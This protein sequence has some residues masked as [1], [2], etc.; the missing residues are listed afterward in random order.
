MATNIISI[1]GPLFMDWLADKGGRGAIDLVM[2]VQ[3]VE[4]K[5]AVEWLSGRDLSQRPADFHT[6][7]HAEEREPRSLEMPA[8]NE[9]RWDAVREYLGG[10]SQ[11]PGSISGSAA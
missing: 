2:H 4:F 10:D 7:A 6:Y 5:E 11:T 8:A 3:E 9:G 1:S